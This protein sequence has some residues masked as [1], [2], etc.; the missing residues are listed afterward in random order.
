MAIFKNQIEDLAGTIPATA[1]GEQ[2][3]A[4]GVIDVVHRMKMLFPEHLPLFAKEQAIVDGGTTL[5]DTDLLEVERANKVCRAIPSSGRHAAVDATSISYAPATDPVYYF[6]NEKIYV[7]PTGGSPTCSIVQHGAVVTWDSEPSGINYMPED[8]YYQV[9]MYAAI[10]VLHHKMVVSTMPTNLTLTTVTAPSITAVVP[11]TPTIATVNYTGPSTLDVSAVTDVTAAT[12]TGISTAPLYTAPSPTLSLEAF[13][14]FAGTIANLSV[15]AVPPDV[16][17][18]ST[19]TLTFTEGAPVY[20]APT[21][22]GGSGADDLSDMIDSSWSGLDFDFDAE[23]IDFATWFQAAG[24]MIQNQEDI[25]LASM[26]LQ[27]IAAYINSY[28][29]SMQ[30]RLNI[31]NDTNTEYQ[32]EFQRAVQNAQLSDAADSKTLSKYQAELG[33]YQQEVNAQVG[34]YTQNLGKA[35]QTWSGEQ[36]NELARFSTL[37]QNAMNVFN[38]ANAEYQ[39]TFQQGVQNAQL[40]NAAKL[41]NMQKDLQIA[42]GNEDRDQQRQLQNAVQDTQAIIANNGNLLGKYQ[43]EVATYQQEVNTQVSEYAQNVQRISEANS[44]AIQDFGARIQKVSG[45]YQW[46]QGQ[47]SMVAQQYNQSFMAGPQ[48]VQ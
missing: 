16:P 43:A 31:F 30:N 33:Q 48:G 26:Q 10:Q 2:F 45:E 32:I 44:S 5:H 47:L 24:A 36:Q 15:T 29:I 8:N 38:D 23:N 42:I 19:T 37:M 21:I 28:S 34:E 13:S 9:I 14:A 22:A 46:L 4:E 39:I 18:L 6:L 20:T 27:K 7:R 11:D 41:S 40:S 25:E 3:L 1:D 17:T 35:I 12:I